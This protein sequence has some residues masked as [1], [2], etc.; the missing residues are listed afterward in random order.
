M[1]IQETQRLNGTDSNARNQPSPTPETY[2]I[3]RLL[4]RE[5]RYHAIDL[6]LE[7]GPVEFGQLVDEVTARETGRPVDDLDSGARDSV[8]VSLYQT[9]LPKLETN[10]IVEYERVSGTI[11]PGPAIDSVRAYMGADGS[12]LE[13]FADSVRALV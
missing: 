3:H 2:K 8:R 11:H 7:R 9:H 4:G 6:L 13:R 12:L 1:Q 5:R 10:G